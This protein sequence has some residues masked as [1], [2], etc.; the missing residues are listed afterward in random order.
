[1]LKMEILFK[2]VIPVRATFFSAIAR[3]NPG[4]LK[5][6]NAFFAKVLYLSLMILNQDEYLLRNHGWMF[7]VRTYES[8]NVI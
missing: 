2:L 1:M 5:L 3:F 6:K 4:N 8:G 7:E